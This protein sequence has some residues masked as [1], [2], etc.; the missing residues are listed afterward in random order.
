MR[1]IKDEKEKIWRRG[2]KVIYMCV[3]REIREENML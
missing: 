3:E 2:K 1:E